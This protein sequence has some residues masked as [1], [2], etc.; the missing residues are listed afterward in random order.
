M[1]HKRLPKFDYLSQVNKKYTE[2]LTEILKQPF[3]E[4]FKKI[5]DELKT[6]NNM[7]LKTF[8]KEMKLIREWDYER[9]KKEAKYV[10]IKANVKYIPKLLDAVLI[11]NIKLLTTTAS[12]KKINLDYE[13]PDLSQFFHRCFIEIGKNFYLE[14]YLI[15]DFKEKNGMRLKNITDSLFLIEKSLIKTINYFIPYSNI[16]DVYLTNVEEDSSEDESSEESVGDLLNEDEDEDEDGDGE[17]QEEEEEEQEDVEEEGE[18]VEQKQQ[19]QEQEQQKQEME[20][21][22]NITADDIGDKNQIT[23]EE[24]D[25]K[26]ITEGELSELPDG[27]NK[28]PEIQEQKIEPRQQIPEPQQKIPEPQPHPQPQEPQPKSKIIFFN[29][30]EDKIDE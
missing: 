29:D 10:I 30:A 3:Y 13:I 18:M 16:L 1:V 2:H 15:C 8:Q 22:I 17:E 9:I 20:K 12:R 19:E 21:E 7:K 14:P 5:S 26:I 4:C 25:D 28:I 27:L 11:S 24:F 6:S 23:I